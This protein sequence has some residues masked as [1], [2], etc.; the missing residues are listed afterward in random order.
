MQQWNII[1]IYQIDNFLKI[2]IPVLVKVGQRNV[3]I[4]YTYHGG[5]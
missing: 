2:L 5:S 3:C 1:F 4:S